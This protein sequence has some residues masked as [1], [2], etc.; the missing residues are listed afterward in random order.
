MSAQREICSRPIRHLYNTG[1]MI[2]DA[3]LWK[4]SRGLL[5]AEWREGLVLPPRAAQAACADSR[6]ASPG[7]PPTPLLVGLV[8]G[9]ASLVRCSVRCSGADSVRMRA[10]RPDEA[11]G[12]TVLSVVGWRAGIT[13]EAKG[14]GS[15]ETCAAAATVPAAATQLAV[16]SALCCSRG[17]L[18]TQNCQTQSPAHSHECP[19]QPQPQ[20]EW[21]AHC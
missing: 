12:D 4:A 13:T 1:S 6:R 21:Q 16:A 11:E 17:D 15:A 9:L 2:K 14:D 19:P 10:K 20:S 3:H 18:D 8:C 5:T 7:L